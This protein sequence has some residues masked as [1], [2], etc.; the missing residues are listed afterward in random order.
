MLPKYSVGYRWN[1]FAFE[2]RLSIFLKNSRLKA[3][4]K[5]EAAPGNIYSKSK[6]TYIIKICQT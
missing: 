1:K 3:A 6:S 5:R 2:A 4:L